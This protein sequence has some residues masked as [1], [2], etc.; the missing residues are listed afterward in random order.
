MKRDFIIDF[1]TLG[2]RN[3]TL[4]AVDCAYTIFDRSRFT[5]RPYTFEELVDTVQKSKFD[6]QKQ[7]ALGF[8]F[9]KE[10]LA[11][12]E[13]QPDE[14]KKNLH[15]TKNDLTYAEF[16]ATL[17]EYL[18]GVK[19]QKWWTRGNNFDPPVLERIMDLSGELD[20]FDAN[21]KFWNVRDVRTFINGV[22]GFEVS[23]GFTPVSDEAY[24]KETFIAH[25][26][27][28]DVAADVMRLQALLRLAE[29]LELTER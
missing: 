10:D 20:W 8:K 27:R 28:H 9:S 12:W 24:W 2:K 1:E 7:T 4:V 3:R 16:S 17:K 29:D 6:V 26:S 14:V 23:S 15:P 13:S 25:D 21:L 22:L 19:V 18:N 5:T 11:W